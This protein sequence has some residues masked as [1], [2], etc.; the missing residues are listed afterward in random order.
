MLLAIG[1][2]TFVAIQTDRPARTL[3]RRRIGRLGGRPLRGYLRG[4]PFRLGG[5]L[6]D[7]SDVHERSLERFLS[8]PFYLAEQFTGFPGQYTPLKDTI[9]SFT[10]LCDGKWDHLPEAAFMYIGA[11]EEAE[12]KAKKL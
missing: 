1:G 12:E 4:Q 3:L 10:E 8:Q 9:R 5:R 2:V 11:V 6:L 7:A